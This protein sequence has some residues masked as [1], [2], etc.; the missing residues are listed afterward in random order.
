MGLF[1]KRRK[2]VRQVPS[3]KEREKERE[4]KRAAERPPEQKKPMGK[5]IPFDP[6]APIVL[7]TKN[8]IF[9]V[10]RES[11]KNFPWVR[12]GITFIIILIGGIGSAAFQ[13]R[14]ANI[15]RDINRATRQLRDYQDSNFALE[16]QLQERYTFYEIER[17]ATER[18]GMSHPDASQIVNIYVPRVG[19]VTL[20][21]ADY[22]LPQHNYFWNDVSNFFSGLFNSIFGGR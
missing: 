5:V 15:Q 6:N 8:T 13:A 1:R 7:V 11:I 16:Q 14:N 2:R 21:T 9:T 22:A 12:L 20:N 17:I 19:G 10:Y 4:Q 3:L 18:L